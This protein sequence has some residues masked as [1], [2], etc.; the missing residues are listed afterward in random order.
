MNARTLS[1]GS[2]RGSMTALVTPF[3]EGQVD[4][5]A[6]DR[7]VDRQIAGDTDWLV[8]CGTTGESPTLSEMEFRRVAKS[9]IERAGGRCRVMVGTGT[10]NTAET[11]HRTRFAA[12]AGADA[13]L[14]V[15]PYYNRPSPEGLFRHY[16][17]IAEAVELPLVLYNVPA[18]TGVN[19]SVETTVRLRN[20]F[21]NIVGVKHA[22]GS[23]DGVSEMVHECDIVV[24]C[25][26]DALTW[27]M[28]ALGASGVISVLGN[29]EPTWMKALVS[30]ALEGNVTR[31]RKLHRRVGEL[32]Q[33]MG[34]F[35]TNPIPIKTALALR[36][37][38]R[39]EFRLPLCAMDETARGGL[40]R[41]LR[42]YERLEAVAA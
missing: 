37:D 20:A 15:T 4:F 5:D 28:M 17:A 22:T 23:V 9:V 7:L 13:A 11:I 3:C 1:P 31:A 14:V 38:I 26:D 32:A 29:L 36:G 2:L 12:E 41:V 19:L 8:P 16:S 35:G 21:G 6:L 18:R 40:E 30:A 39:E 34:S 33:A 27:P 10:Y 25:G 42:K 24:L